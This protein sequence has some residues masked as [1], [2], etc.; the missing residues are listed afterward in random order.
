MWKLCDEAT[1]DMIF[2]G[3][4]GDAGDFNLKGEDFT[5]HFI[6]VIQGADPILREFRTLDDS[7]KVW[8]NLE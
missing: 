8:T 6:G 4:S 7:Y 5:F 1:C 3:R 2:M